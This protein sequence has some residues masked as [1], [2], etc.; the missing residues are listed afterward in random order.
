MKHKTSWL[1]PLLLPLAAVAQDADSIPA[2]SL[3]EVLVITTKSAQHKQGKLLSSLDEYLSGSEQLNLV[4]RGAYAWEPLLNGMASERSVITIDGMRIYM[5]CTDKMDPV[6]SYVETSNLSKAVVKSGQAGAAHG[7]TVAGSIDLVRK[8][9]GFGAAA[10]QTGIVTGYE[11]NNRQRILGADWQIVRPGFYADLDFTYRKADNYKAGDKQEI[12]YSQFTKY[13]LSA[14]T[15]F[16]W[17]DHQQ[18]EASLIFDNAS[19]IGYPALPMDVALARAA[20]A[21]LAYTRHHISPSVHQWETKI[22]YNSVTHRMDDS[23]RPDV[24]VRMDMPGWTKTAGVYSV[25][26]GASSKHNWKASLSGHHNSSLAE[27]TMF[28]NNPGE[29]D[30]YMLTWPGVHTYYGGIF[31][32]DRFR[33][34]NEWMLQGSAG[35]AL[36]QNQIRNE[37]GLK[38]LEIFYPLIQ[39]TQ[40][41]ALKNL[42]AGLQYQPSRWNFSVGASYGERAPSVSEG[43]GFYLFNSFDRYDYIGNPNLLKEKSIEFNAGATYTDSLFQLKWKGSFFHVMDYI[44]GM[45]DNSYIPM[46]IG[47]SGVRIYGQIPFAQIWNTS[48]SGAWQIFKS[49]SVSTRASYRRG[50][51]DQKENLPLI[52]PFSYGAKLQYKTSK[53]NAEL[54]MDGAIRQSRYSISFGENPAPDYTIFNIT[55]GYKFRFDK[56]NMIFNAGVENLFDRHY[57]TFADWNRVPRMG[58]NFF[59]SLIIKLR[60]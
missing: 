36:Q 54:V 37:M 60:S 38:S 42:S 28:S 20:I 16:K 25:L 34:S 52:Q 43:Y 53:L 5:A 4:K 12:L 14:I 48:F 58:R 41:R 9:A 26:S 56:M 57:T 1:W 29:K 17:N 50:L 55:A 6:T 39:Q 32:E 10:M 35:W 19:D 11:S 30:M 44:M 3:Q 27:M 49:I 46:T 45:T 13:N 22:Y 7:A 47:A 21:S 18:L 23:D 8:K 15:G 51:S 31:M 40:T 33:I 59:T 24:P 2:K